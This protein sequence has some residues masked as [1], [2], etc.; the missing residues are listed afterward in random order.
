MDCISSIL[1]SSVA[2]QD[3]ELVESG[4]FLHNI[5]SVSI[6][7]SFAGRAELLL[8]GVLHIKVHSKLDG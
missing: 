4:V 5:C 2:R 8:D 3:I 6:V 7:L 1:L